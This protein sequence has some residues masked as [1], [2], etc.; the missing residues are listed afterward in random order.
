ML[1]SLDH[2]II[3]VQDLDAASETY[4]SLLGR[5][6]SWRGEHLEMGTANALFRLEN[7]YLE[8]AHM[9]K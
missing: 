1:H 7:T 2:A 4:A 5:R 8:L 6:P 3:V 9:N